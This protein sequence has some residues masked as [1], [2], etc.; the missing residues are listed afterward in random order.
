VAV[1]SNT[2]ASVA[3]ASLL[4]NKRVNLPNLMQLYRSNAQQE[5]TARSITEGNHEKNLLRF[6]LSQL[7]TKEK[8]NYI[9]ATKL[10]LVHQKAINEKAVTPAF[11]L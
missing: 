6:T 4:R 10:G 1:F 7:L 3:R 8:D 11:Q 5:E 2:V 9:G